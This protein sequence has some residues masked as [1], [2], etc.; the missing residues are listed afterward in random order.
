MCGVFSQELPAAL[1]A[2]TCCWSVVMRSTLGR[3]AAGAPSLPAQRQ[4][5]QA[6]IP[7]LNNREMSRP[8]RHADRRAW[9]RGQVHGVTIE[10]CNWASTSFSSLCR[11]LDEFEEL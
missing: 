9:M 1:V 10:G 4:D 11:C 2:V 5:A 8:E 3:F 7:P 6:P